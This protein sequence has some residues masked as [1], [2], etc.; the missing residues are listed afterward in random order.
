M[1]NSSTARLQHAI[2]TL[3]EGN[4]AEA[5][6]LILE[7][8]KRNPSNLNAWLWALEVAANEKEKR[9]ILSRILSLDPNHKGALL[10][11]KKLDEGSTQAQKIIGPQSDLSKVKKQSSQKKVSRIGGLFRLLFGWL[12]SLP[13]SCA[14]ILVI[15]AVVIA[16]FVYFRVNTSFFGIAG[17]DFD[18]LI[19]TN[20][21]EI[22][23]SDEFYWE[24]QFEGIGES[25][26]IGTVRHI[27][28]FRMKIFKIISHDILV[29]TAD[30]AT[31]SPISTGHPSLRSRS[32]KKVFFDRMVAGGPLRWCKINF[33]V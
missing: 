30:F 24:V 8:I 20:A 10:Y 7:E 1:D 15:I 29:T 33:I 2:N 19:I 21:Y 4:L 3:N 18:D 17:S 16:G 25:K 31:R 12:S 9:T 6:E 5:R 26:Y 27:A 13:V 22:I 23:E 14:F 32:A 11:L 28:P